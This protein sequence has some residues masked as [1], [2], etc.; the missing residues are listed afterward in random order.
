MEERESGKQFLLNECLAL[1]LSQVNVP[2]WFGTV[3]G[4][5]DP[6]GSHSGAF[7]TGLV[8]KS[9]VDM[10]DLWHKDSSRLLQPIHAL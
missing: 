8:P 7:V 3:L 5:A 10:V 1:K 2:E 6:R 9:E 4:S